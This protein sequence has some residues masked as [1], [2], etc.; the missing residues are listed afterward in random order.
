MWNAVVRRRVRLPG[1]R[2]RGRFSYQLAYTYTNS[3][4]T[5]HPINGISVIDSLNNPIEQYNS[6]TKACAGVTASS[7]NW[8]ACGSGKYPGNAQSSFVNSGVTIPNPY[9]DRPIQSLLD[10]NGSYSPQN[11]IASLFNGAN[12]YE[13]PNVVSVVLNYRKNK[14]AITP[15]LR[16]DDGA[17]YGSP[18]VWPGYVLQSCTKPPSSMPLTPGATCRSLHAAVGPDELTRRDFPARSL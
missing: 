12:S 8:V 17:S 1:R 4:L 18:L 10:P 3:H 5:F 2:F 9:Y 14:F 13:V 16:F 11:V 6:Y 7:P 15:T